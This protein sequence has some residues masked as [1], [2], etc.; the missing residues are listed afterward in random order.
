MP[1]AGEAFVGQRLVRFQFPQLRLGCRGLGR[2]RGDPL[3]AAEHTL[4]Q[5]GRISFQLAERLAALGIPHKNF[6]GP[7]APDDLSAV[8]VERHAIGEIAL[9]GGCGEIFSS[10][11]PNLH[12]IVPT[13]RNDAAVR[14]EGGG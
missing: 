7:I 2:E 8:V 11:I 5:R 3:R 10:Q 14:R 6:P 12:F 13:A 1:D 4:S 9:E